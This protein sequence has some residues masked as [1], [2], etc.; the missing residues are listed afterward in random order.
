VQLAFG[1][2]NAEG[3]LKPVLD[4]LKARAAASCPS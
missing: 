4:D 3:G 2:P 1:L